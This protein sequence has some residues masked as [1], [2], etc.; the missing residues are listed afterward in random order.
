MNNIF[1]IGKAGSGKDTAAS[2]L[3][4]H[5]YRLYAFAEPIRAEYRRFFP[6]K[7]PRLDRNKMIDIGQAYK[8]LYGENV[9][10]LETYKKIQAEGEVLVNPVAITDG[11][12]A[13]E[14][15]YFVKQLG[16]LP[17]RICCPD[18]IRL[19]RLKKRDGSAQEEALLKEST[20]LDDVF[21]YRVD[22]SKD[23]LYTEYQL[24]YMVTMT[25]RHF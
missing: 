18:D 22:N 17:I 2:F 10:A 13:V 8:K 1:L 21:A 23:L 16:Y 4:K 25:S 20:E 11:R 24:N 19:Q 12:Y 9:W 7:N 15:D 5:G 3:A 6:D 14:Y